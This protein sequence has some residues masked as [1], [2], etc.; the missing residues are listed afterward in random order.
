MIVKEYITW[1]ESFEI[2]IEEIDKQHKHLVFLLN[3]LYQTL[4]QNELLWDM[5][6]N[7]SKILQELIKYAEYHFISEENLMEN[8]NFPELEC[9]KNIHEYFRKR[10]QEFLSEFEREINFRELGLSIFKF[11]KVWVV[12]HILNDDKKIALFLGKNFEVLKDVYQLHGLVTK[13]ILFEEFKKWTEENKETLI[14]FIIIDLDNFA[15]IN[16][17][18][19]FEI[20]NIILENFSRYLLQNLKNFE[21]SP[22]FSLAKLE[23]DR[24]GLLFKSLN[25]LKALNLIETILKIIRKYEFK[26]P[27][28]FEQHVIKLSAS[29]GVSFYPIHSDKMEELFLKAEIA[30]KIAKEEG[31][32][33]FVLF[34][35]EYQKRFEDFERI[36]SL[37]EEAIEKERVEPFIQPIF[38]TKTK[39]ILGG[40]VLLRICD[41]ENNPVSACQFIKIALKLGYINEL[42]EIVFKK[43]KAKNIFENLKDYYLF[44]NRTISSFEECEKVIKEVKSWE[45]LAQEFNFKFVLEVTE[46]SLVRYL[47]FFETLEEELQKSEHFFLA[48]DDFGA[49]YAS[50][51]YLLKFKPHFIK[52][53]G[54]LVR[55]TLNSD[56][57]KKI[58]KVIITL[59]REFKIRAIAEHVENQTLLKTLEEF[60]VDYVQ[61]Y[62]LACPMSVEKFL[63]LIA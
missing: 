17:R 54:F 5:E 44:V 7:L 28:L 61:G 10:V 1:D 40:E 3:N 33:R 35:E 27:Y 24:F 21:L 49:G 63:T 48:V 42:E 20:G 23:N 26:A 8:L 53:D 45:R 11:M 38:E 59:A 36:K 56:R 41:R 62:Y 47:E 18:Y 58:L 60:E 32:N 4:F 14:S 19:G 16:F 6:E 15:L 55:E 50:F 46:N 22:N 2:G 30:C 37:I 34:K 25:F 52:I 51:N 57:A 29:L 13:E 9:H 39:K 43:L 12:N 31:K